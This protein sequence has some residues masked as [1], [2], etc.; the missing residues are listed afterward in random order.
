MGLQVRK[1]VSHFLNNATNT[2]LYGLTISENVEHAFQSKVFFHLSGNLHTCCFST[3]KMQL[4]RESVKPPKG[5]G[6]IGSFVRTG[7]QV[8][9]STCWDQYVSPGCTVGL[10][11]FW[12]FLHCISML[13]LSRTLLGLGSKSTSLI[14][15]FCVHRQKQYNLLEVESHFWILIF[16]WLIDLA[17]G[18]NKCGWC[19]AGSR[20]CW[21]KGLHQ[22]LSVSWL[23]HHSSQF[24]IY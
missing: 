12:V 4:S 15:R 5:S 19:L 6:P 1:V 23:F 3:F 7:F 17:D 24:H 16:F 13:I 11:F 21:F 18:I 22:I 2:C 8:Y 14:L 20:E 10:A 9:L